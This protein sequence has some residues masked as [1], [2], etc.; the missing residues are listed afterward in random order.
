M[1]IETYKMMIPGEI[2]VTFLNYGGIIQSLKV[3][4]K[5]GVMED[6]VLGFDE[7]ESYTKDHPYFGALIGRYANRIRKGKFTLEGKEYQLNI[8]NGP[9]SL[10]GGLIGFDRVFWE[11]EKD[12]DG[13]SYTLRHESPHMHE[14]YPGKLKIEVTYTVTAGRDFVIDYKATTDRPTPINFT[15]HS[16]FNLSGGK[17]ETIL[18]HELWIN[19]QA[20]TYVD[21]DLTPTGKIIEVNKDF[22]FR[23]HKR[24]GKDIEH[25]HG[26]YDHNY[27]LFDVPIYD[28]KARLVEPVSGRMMEV[29]TTEPGLQ[30]YSG[31]FLDGSIQGK[32][33]QRYFKHAGLCLET[34]HFPDS[35]NHPEFPN[36]ILSPDSPYYSKTIYK[37]TAGK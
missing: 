4:D 24:I 8:N 23:E 7:P 3:P 22:D 14:G 15:N 13:H 33:G 6:V 17:S 18:D 37:F 19:S 31:N 27:I 29:F 32:N 2:E 10:H 26:G 12:S 1:K 11:V 5:N 34:Q 35:P 9:N 36:T 20:I 30:F 16:Y 25:V 21:K 28:P